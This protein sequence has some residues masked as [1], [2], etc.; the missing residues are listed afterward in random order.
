MGLYIGSPVCILSR[1]M[2]AVSGA[3]RCLSRHHP[4]PPPQ[5]TLRRGARVRALLPW[6]VQALP[7]THDMTIRDES[8]VSQLSIG[9]TYINGVQGAVSPGRDARR[10]ECFPACRLGGRGTHGRL[11]PGT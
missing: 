2:L 6:R 5:S 9:L 10:R 3:I 8:A 4:P 7:H 1:K 11:R